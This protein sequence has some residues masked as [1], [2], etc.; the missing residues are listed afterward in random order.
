MNK[1]LKYALAAVVAVG[2]AFGTASAAEFDG[3]LVIGDFQPL[4]GSAAAGGI[5]NHNA[6]KLAVKQYNEGSHPLNPTPGLK[7]GDKTYK[8]TTAVYDHKYTAEGGGDVRA[9][10][11]LR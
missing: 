2:T 9:Q 11:G 10:A 5:N 7:V 6:L 4:S 1:S 8:L 3:E